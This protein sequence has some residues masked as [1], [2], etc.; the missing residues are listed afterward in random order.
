MIDSADMWNQHSV[1]AQNVDRDSASSIGDSIAPGSISIGYA[2][3]S[4]NDLGTLVAT[5]LASIISPRFPDQKDSLTRN[6]EGLTMTSAAL[7]ANS[8]PSAA[9][10]PM[11]REF[12]DKSES[13]IEWAWN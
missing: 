3:Q 5:S 7:A 10:T 11:L 9:E 12:T 4:E 8:H 13:F 6:D 2:H 1:N